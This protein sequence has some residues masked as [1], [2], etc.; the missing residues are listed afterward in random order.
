MDQARL[1][2]HE[3]AQGTSPLISRFRRFAAKLG[4]LADIQGYKDQIARY[5]G[6]IDQA[7][8]RDDQSDADDRAERREPAIS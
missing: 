6:E 5:E 8:H 3:S 1:P 7:A 4:V 2:N